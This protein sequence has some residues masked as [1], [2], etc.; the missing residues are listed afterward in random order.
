VDA[1]DVITM[2]DNLP[3]VDYERNHN[4]RDAIERCPTGAIVWYDPDK[5]PVTGRAARRVVRR[6]ARHVAPT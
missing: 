3:V 1:P 6:S 5:G 4:V 2:V